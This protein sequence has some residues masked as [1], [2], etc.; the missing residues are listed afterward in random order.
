MRKKRRV[1]LLLG[2]MLL[3]GFALPVWALADDIRVYVD[4]SE[5]IFW[6]QKPVLNADNR[7]LVPIRYVSQAL[8]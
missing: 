6:D 2:V 4:N 8:G 5:V 7:I 3:V 1:I